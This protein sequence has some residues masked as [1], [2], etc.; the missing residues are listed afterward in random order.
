[1][2]GSPGESVLSRVVRIVESFGSDTPALRVS[3]IARRADL[4]I[5]TASRLIEELVGHGWLHRHAD[6]RIRIGVRLW[7]LASRAS[8]T[9][10]LREAAMPFLEDLHT[11]V[12]HHVQLGVRE[13]R[14]ALFVER[15]SAPGAIDSLTHVAGRLPLHA[16]S[17]GLVLLA[18]APA[19]LQERVLAEPLPAYTSLT[20]V[21]PGQLRA[22]LAEVRTS[23]SALC[24]GFI[25]T[26]AAGVAVPLRGPDE[27][28]V[29]ALSVIVPNDDTARMHVPALRAAARGISRAMGTHQRLA[30]RDL[31][32]AE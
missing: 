12:G 19:W 27:T 11:A 29:A 10:D 22:L 20:V 25:D 4:H 2:A 9:L 7:E 17:A 28:V 5:A 13:E 3:E 14:E 1:M 16:S 31:R 32:L 6:R 26:R 24:R 23:G 30:P 15:L 21:D 8:P 18:H